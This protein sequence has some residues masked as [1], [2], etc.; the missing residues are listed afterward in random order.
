V[1]WPEA[2]VNEGVLPRDVFG[3]KL[4]ALDAIRMQN[5]V[6]IALLPAIGETWRIKIAAL[7]LI[8][9]EAAEAHLQTM[10]DKVKAESMG[11]QHDL[12]MILD[13]QEGMEVRLEEAEDWWPNRHDRVVPR[14]L[15]SGMME[16]PGSFRAE[17]LHHTQ[18]STIQRSFQLALEAVRHKKG[19]YDLAI[20]LGCV[21]M[22][23]KH[24]KDEDIG[25]VYK[26]EVFQKS[27][28]GP[29]G[30]DVK[31]WWVKPLNL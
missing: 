7:E 6:F 23:S 24:I 9:I 12:N 16:E 15:P 25:K 1:H 13:D 28:D 14:L 26:K 17:F 21:A 31:K 10:I 30:L 5:E 27:I 19:A 2:L 3:N 8:N 20:R 29:I 11:S 22:S 4:E 18:L